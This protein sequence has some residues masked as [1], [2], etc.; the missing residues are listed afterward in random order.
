MRKSV[1]RRYQIT[2]PS[3]SVAKG[4][5]AGPSLK[6]TTGSDAI[7]PATVSGAPAT[8]SQSTMTS[9]ASAINGIIARI[10]SAGIT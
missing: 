5:F 8:Y 7:E 6:M 4:R 10:N 1:L 2:R 3:R 9:Y